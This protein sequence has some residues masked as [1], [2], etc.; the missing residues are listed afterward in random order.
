[1]KLSICTNTI[2]KIWKATIKC[3]LDIFYLDETSFLKCS[4]YIFI[5]V[6]LSLT[7]LFV[8][9][10]TQCAQSVA[11][12]MWSSWLANQLPPPAH[13]SAVPLGRTLET[14]R[15]PSTPPIGLGAATPAMRSLNS[16][17]PLFTADRKRKHTHSLSVL[18]RR[19]HSLSVQMFSQFSN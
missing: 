14:H 13:P 16:F 8:Q 5:H 17:G 19:H 9:E 15:S 18:F 7:C 4:I 1:M 6:Y 2:I 12:I 11:V 10:E 3:R